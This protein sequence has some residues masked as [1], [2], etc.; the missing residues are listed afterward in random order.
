M[1][2]PLKAP[3]WVQQ[4]VPLDWYERYGRRIEEYLSIAARECT[5]VVGHAAQRIT[6]HAAQVA[7]GL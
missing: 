1:P 7:P 3:A 4:R 2:W 5:T 6:G